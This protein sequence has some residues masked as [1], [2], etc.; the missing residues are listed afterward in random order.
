MSASRLPLRKIA[1][2]GSG[3]VGCYYGGK[4]ARGQA[5]V[6]LLMRRD[7][8][9][10]RRHGLQIRS[11]E[12]DFSLPEVR[13]H[14]STSSIGP[15]DLVIVALKATDNEVL[16]ALLP[17]LLHEQTM[18]LT[19]QNG[20]GNEAWLA[21]RFG[22]NRVLGGLC[23]VCLNRTSPGV[24]EHYSQG[25]IALGEHCGQ[26]RERTEAVVEHFR[27]CG[28]DCRL[29]ENL[30]RARWSKLVWNVPFNGL[31]I[32]AGGV[33]VGVILADESL[34]LLA[35]A[36]M[37]E[38]IGTANRLG[39]EIPSSFIEEQ[40]SQTAQMGPYKPSSLI[41]YLNG[42]PVEVESIWGEAYRQGVASGSPVGHLETVYHLLKALCRPLQ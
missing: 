17:P 38:I 12:G 7:L 1:I 2:V 16:V 11:P 19:L 3:A 8:E 18:I 10:V 30:E 32:V 27:Q 4:L 36:L 5:E 39:H 13:A 9:H 23:L 14:G 31:A 29:V 26:P 6:H 42:R 15:V 25:A 35:R 34:V 22:R 24:V 28:I 33:D 41:D 21:Q 40:F 37:R 20:L